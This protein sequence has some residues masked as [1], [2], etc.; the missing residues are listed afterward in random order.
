MKR[1]FFKLL[2]LI[3]SVLMLC[4]CFVSCDEDGATA[5]GGESQ[6]GSAASDSQTN[7]DGSAEGDGTGGDGEENNGGENK[8]Y[9]EK[10]EYNVAVRS[11]YTP[12]FDA[13]VR[14]DYNKNGD[15]L[16]FVFLDEETLT[17]LYDTIDEYKTFVY[18]G[19]GKLE[20][21][22]LESIPMYITAAE[23]GLSASGSYTLRGVNVNVELEY[24]AEGRL[25]KDYYYTVWGTEKVLYLGVE[26]NTDG[27][28]KKCVY[29]GD[30]TSEYTRDG[31]KVTIKEESIGYSYDSATGE[32][33]EKLITEYS[34]VTYAEGGMIT[35]YVDTDG[36]VF[37]Y[38][39]DAS[40]NCVS[41]KEDGVLVAT[42]SYDS[43]G[44]PIKADHFLDNADYN[45]HTTFTYNAEG[46]ILTSQYKKAYTSVSYQDTEDHKVEFIYHNGGALDKIEYTYSRTDSYPNEGRTKNSK[47]YYKFNSKNML[48]EKTYAS[49]DWSEGE[50]EGNVEEKTVYSEMYM[51]IEE[52]ETVTSDDGKLIR[53]AKIVRTLDANGDYAKSEETAAY[54]TDGGVRVD[55][56]TKKETVIKEYTEGKL[57]KTTTTVETFD[58]SGKVTSSNTTTEP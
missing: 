29:A 50:L 53:E 41:C 57:T 46:D 43:Q 40:G 11:V 54:Y 51:P 47:W 16:G 36:D 19:E 14:L 4:V 7:A 35:Q 31:S 12:M 3:L 23:D 24:D 5:D 48:L 6:T 49:D 15:H 1:N 55:Y 52:T 42:V 20:L 37:D 13:F 21:V 45:A 32:G 58:A 27:S 44:R 39:Y 22:V 8:P 10:N 34:Y 28:I 17:P 38:T 25:I 2:A 56:M 26:Y 18:D 33:T 30:S 9:V